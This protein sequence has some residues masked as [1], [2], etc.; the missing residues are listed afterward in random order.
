MTDNVGVAHVDFWLNDYALVGSATTPPYSVPWNASVYSGVFQFRARA[1]DTA[2]NMAQTALVTVTVPTDQTPPAVAITSPVEGATIGA[3]SNVQISATDTNGIGGLELYDGGTL[4]NSGLSGPPWSLDYDATDRPDGPHTLTVHAM[5]LNGNIGISAPVHVT[6]DKTPPTIAITAP[7]N[8]VVVSGTVNFKA[9]VADNGTI[10]FVE[11]YDDDILLATDTAAPYA[12]TWNTLGAP[13]RGHVLLVRAYDTV[14][15][16]GQAAI[17]VT[18]LPDATPPTVSITAPANGAVIT[19]TVAF[20]ATAGDNIGVARVELRDGN[21]VVATL[22]SSP[23]TFNWN[24][25]SVATGTHTLTARA[26]D[27]AGNSATSA[28]RSVTIDRTAPTVA[29]SAPASGATVSGTVTVSATASD[30]AGLARVEFYRDGTILI[31]TDTTSPYSISWNTTTTA[32]G[33]HP[34]TARA[35]DIAGNAKTSSSRSVTVKDI[36]A[37]T[38]SLTSPANGARVNVGA[39]ITM[40]ATATDATGVTKVEFRV[41]NVLTCTDQTAPYTCAWKVPSGTNK[42]YTLV[43]KAYDAA[44]N[45]RTATVSVTSR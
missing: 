15:N 23:Y 6:V 31:G 12:T 44:S 34:L 28:S 4:V 30:S 24:T 25:A 18:I 7:A 19:G 5:D 13:A 2:G 29:L 9:N 40:A 36:T 38:V 22:T 41:N 26:F 42:T 37:P 14:G 8:G 17:V 21:T 35:F 45:T 39:T 32:A 1:Y 20:T 27:A 11:F 16:L 33:S 3:Y 43:A 10:A